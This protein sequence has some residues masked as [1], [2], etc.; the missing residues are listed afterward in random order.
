MTA[1]AEHQDKFNPY[2]WNVDAVQ[3]L[4]VHHVFC[5]TR[6]SNTPQNRLITVENIIIYAEEDQCVVNHTINGF[7][8]NLSS[9]NF[10]NT[11]SM[12]SYR[13]KHS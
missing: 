7:N 11:I 4:R 5:H 1:G 8:A 13:S 2:S 6:L 3:P 12:K 10:S 9:G